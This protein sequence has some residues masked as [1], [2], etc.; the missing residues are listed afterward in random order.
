[1][2]SCLPDH[3]RSPR[4]RRAAGMWRRPTAGCCGCSCWSAGAL[5]IVPIDHDRAA[6]R[7]TAEEHHASSAT[8]RSSCE[9]LSRR[10]GLALDTSQ[11]GVWE[12]N[13]ET[14]ELFWDDRMNELY[15]FPRDGGSRDYAHWARS[16]ASRR[17]GARRGRI[18]T[19]RIDD[20]RQLPFGV[21]PAPARRRGPPHPRHRHGLQGRRRTD[22]DRRRQLGRDRPTSRSTRT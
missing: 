1:M 20:Q 19:A 9:R 22:E 8:A 5:I 18:P 3:G 21:P 13:I 11:I 7:G 15:G 17:P 6:D 16:A 14:D 12:Y 2:S 4:S 10:L